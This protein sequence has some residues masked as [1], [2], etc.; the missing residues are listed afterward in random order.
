MKEL[1]LSWNNRRFNNVSNAY[2]CYYSGHFK[3][4]Y[5]AKLPTV[6]I[7][8]KPNTGKSTL[9]NRLVGRRK[10]IVSDTPGTTRD[11]IAA[12]VRTQTVDFLLVDTGGMG[13]G[14]EDID[15]ED[16]VQKQS[17]LALE[18]ADLILFT[19]NSREELTSSDM[20][21]VD[22]L[23][24]S[25]R[26]HVPVLLVVTK[27]DD[28]ESI[29]V[30]TSQY[31]QLDIAKEIIPVSAPHKIGIDDLLANI[32]QELSALHFSKQE[33]VDG[34][35]PNIAI[36]GKPNVGKSS[37]VNAFMS[38][39]QRGKSPLLVSDIAGTTRDTTDTV[40]R[41]NEKDYLFMDTA[42]LKRRKQTEEDIETHAT[43][44]SMKAID[45]CDIAVLLI[46][47]TQPISKQDKRIAQ[48]V[49]EEGKGLIILINKIDL[50]SKE[51]RKERLDHIHDELSFCKFAP[52]LPCSA[53]TRE[54]LLKLFE[55]IET[56]ERNRTRH[57][58]TKPLREWFDSITNG[59]QTQRILR[60]KFITQVD[61]VPPTFVIFVKDPKKVP[62]S[63]LRFL[64]NRIRETFS[65]E[66]TPIKWIT[67]TST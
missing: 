11:Q 17:S 51:D 6:A 61:E 30:I 10:A 50:L 43:F 1:L 64:E 45:L 55:L 38:E 59:Q 44:R 32:E 60:S 53:N 14:T 18:N 31:Y 41:F 35:L 49:I 66:G 23:R 21:I 42:G 36:I 57:I 40:I 15:L 22:I 39:T 33:E 26:D 63:Q 54:G 5:M 27:C 29:D 62:V 47:S 56:V 3:A 46:D 19:V 34:K 65:F 24:K 37:L 48:M 52:M 4:L 28:T 25:K 58:A 8:G 67:K 7:I 9:F 2:L 12:K 20:E 13:G 16:D